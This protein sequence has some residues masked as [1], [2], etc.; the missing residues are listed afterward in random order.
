[1]VNSELNYT[2]LKFPPAGAGNSHPTPRPRLTTNYTKVVTQD[3]P[4]PT[5]SEVETRL[6]E[7]TENLGRDVGETVDPFADEST[8]NDPEAFYDRPPPARP[9]AQ[10]TVGP[11]PWGAESERDRGAN[12]QEGVAKT[13][14][15]DGDNSA[16]TT[17][18]EDCTGG[19]AYMDTSQFLRTNV[20]SGTKHSGIDPYFTPPDEQP[21]LVG[22]P[23][24]PSTPTGDDTVGGFGPYDFPAA[25]AN[26]PS[27]GG[28]RGEKG[29][30]SGR[31]EGGEEAKQSSHSTGVCVCERGRERER[32][33][34]CVCVR[35]GERESVCVC[36]RGRERESVCVCV[37][38]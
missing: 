16:D 30:G 18:D 31:R 19:S 34:V 2:E 5:V 12:S 36:E 26:F 10:L 11:S 14:G 37:C 20:P 3:K 22:S 8:W 23:D 27:G 17:A 24:G 33:C 15:S 38:V 25:L 6:Q 9:V 32:E 1:M 21:G 7:A 29:A 28:G 4:I 13:D 35:E